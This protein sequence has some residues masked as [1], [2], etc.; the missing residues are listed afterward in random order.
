MTAESSTRVPFGPTA[1]GGTALGP[2]RHTALSFAQTVS[3]AREQGRPFKAA[4]PYQLV[5]I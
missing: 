4:A 1:T 3:H 2:Y 5:W